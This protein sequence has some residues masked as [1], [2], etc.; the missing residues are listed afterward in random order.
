M[1]LA[2]PLKAMNAVYLVRYLRAE[3]AL[4]TRE[5]LQPVIQRLDERCRTVE[6]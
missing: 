5:E 1:E 6:F 4:F 3:K 2:Y